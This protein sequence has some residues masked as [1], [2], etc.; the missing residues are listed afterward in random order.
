VL[1]GERGQDAP[2]GAGG[3]WPVIDER[4]DPAVVRQTSDL[5]CVSACGEMLLKDRGVHTVSQ[6]DLLAQLGAPAITIRL[7]DALNR[8]SHSGR[9][10]GDYLNVPTMGGGRAI[11]ILSS[12]G[13]WAAAM[14]EVGAKIDHAVV[15]DGAGDDGTVGVRDPFEATSYRMTVE[16]FLKHWTWAAIWDERPVPAEEE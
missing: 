12:F 10:R 16:D 15:I 6:A 14:R 3:H 4:P 1:S 5:S 11:T 2:A 8:L 7:A 9:W 13:S